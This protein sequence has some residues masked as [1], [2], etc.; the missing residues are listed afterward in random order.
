MMG[1]WCE[2]KGPSSEEVAA[3]PETGTTGQIAA[4]RARLHSA[5][6]F[7]DNLADEAQKAACRLIEHMKS[8]VVEVSNDQGVLYVLEL[9]P[10][11]YC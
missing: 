2:P 9:A 5:G 6:I 10:G 7:G 1:G 4:A 8:D 11:A 3:V